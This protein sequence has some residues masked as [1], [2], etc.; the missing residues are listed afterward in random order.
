MQINIDFINPCRH[1][2]GRGVQSIINNPFVL[3]KK[4]TKKR[5]VRKSQNTNSQKKL[6][7]DQ[8][9]NSEK[10]HRKINPITKKQKYVTIKSLKYLSNT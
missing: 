9:M 1:D 10:K 5:T 8:H 3:K 2:N 4:A 6:E 7:C